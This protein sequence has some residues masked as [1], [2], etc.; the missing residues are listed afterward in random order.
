MPYVGGL[1]LPFTLSLDR[2]SCFFKED[3]LMTCRRIQSSHQFDQGV[4]NH[5]IKCLTIFYRPALAI[6]SKALHRPKV[7]L[8][9]FPKQTLTVKLIGGEPSLSRTLRGSFARPATM[10]WPYGLPDVPSSLFFTITAFFPAYL[11]VSRITT[12]PGC[13]TPKKP[14]SACKT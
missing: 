14:R 13:K 9:T 11:P 12:L 3:R 1:E 6:A 2:F 10:A 5:W 4:N 7:Q 8:H